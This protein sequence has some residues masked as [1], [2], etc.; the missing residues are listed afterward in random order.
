[1]EHG[2]DPLGAIGGEQPGRPVVPRADPAHQAGLAE[3]VLVAVV[4]VLAPAFDLEQF[5]AEPIDELVFRGNVVALLAGDEA[6]DLGHPLPWPPAVGEVPGAGT[7]TRPAAGVEALVVDGHRLASGVS[8]PQGHGW[9]SQRCP[10]SQRC[11]PSWPGWR[12]QRHHSGSGS[13]PFLIAWA[14]KQTTAW[15][16]IVAAAWAAAAVTP[17]AGEGWRQ[18]GR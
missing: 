15:T 3:H 7:K 9:A 10:H 1:L 12:S 2:Q 4:D 13:V 17:P 5:R 11:S 14:A 16:R 18:A 8:Q 6:R